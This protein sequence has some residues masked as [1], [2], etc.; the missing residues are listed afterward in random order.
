MPVDVY[1]GTTGVVLPAQ[2]SNQIWQGTQE[3]S[4]VMRAATPIPLPGEGIQVPIITGDP[5][6]GWVNET[7]EIGVSR[8]SLG[9]KTIQ[10]YK[11]GVIVPF[12]NEFRRDMGTLYNVL[13]S[14]LPLA[15]A[16][17]F[18]QTVFG[19]AAGAPGSNFDTLGAAAAI[20]IGGKS[21]NGLL[22]S[23]AAV[24]TGTIDG[25]LNGWVLSPAGRAIIQGQVDS[26]G[27]P[28]FFPNALGPNGVPDIFGA[29]VYGSRAVY[30]A[31]A[32]GAGAGTDKQYGYA[33]DWSQ[34]YYGTVEDIEITILNEATI[35][36]GGTLLHLAQRDMFAVR[37]KVTVGFRVRDISYFVKLT[38]ATQS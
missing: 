37:V 32:D 16:K 17:K 3:Q 35:N 1:R 36:D 18:D 20:G 7:D 22:A 31:D 5:T 11:L 27:R 24:A 38:S 19:L 4:G 23:Q 29:P 28:I 10:G 33:G 25:E 9:S 13:V 21:Y 12:S 26:T 30:L 2:V 6:A 15:L 34:A 8:P 14:R